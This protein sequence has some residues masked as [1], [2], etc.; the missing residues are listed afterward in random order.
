MEEKRVNTHLMQTGPAVNTEKQKSMSDCQL[1]SSASLI[2]SPLLKTQY[3]LTSS[4]LRYNSINIVR[5]H[6]H[7]LLFLT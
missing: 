2:F 5:C 6:S 1:T 7:H 3:T 4:S